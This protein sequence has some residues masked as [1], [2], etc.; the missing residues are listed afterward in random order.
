MY[1][2]YTA[3]DWSNATAISDIYGWNDGGSV[4]P[5]VAVDGND[6][7]HVVWEDW[8]VGEWGGGATDTEIMYANYTTA[9]WLNATVISDDSTRW[10]N[11]TSGVP[12]VAVDGSGNVYVVWCDDTN[13]IWGTDL[14]IMYATNTTT[15][16]SNATV[17][18]DVYGWNNDDSNSPSIAADNNSVVHVVWDDKTDGEWGND[19][20]ILY[21][22][23]GIPTSNHPLDIITTA[24]SSETINWIL[25]DSSGEGQYRVWV[26]DSNNNNYVWVNWTPWTNN[27]NLKVPI[28]RSA[29]GIFSY[30]IEYNDSYHQFGISDTVFVSVTS[31]IRPP[32][33]PPIG[34]NP[35]AM[36]VSPFNLIIFVGIVAAFTIMVITLVKQQK[37]IKGLREKIGK[38]P[39]SKT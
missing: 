2:N 15:G 14:E 13:G 16:W 32:F 37:T 28:N 25:C 35:S 31:N 20:E 5:N 27:T 4:Y 7:V 11:D 39:V 12:S 23:S 38:T 33:F 24:F 17:I 8:T 26:T 6:N 34:P 1:A 19:W 3:A 30:T 21:S 22:V 18:S 9:G 36:L 10:N 29:E